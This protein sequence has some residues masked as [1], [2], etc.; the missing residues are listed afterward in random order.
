MQDKVR[1]RQ[2]LTYLLVSGI[3]TVS[4]GGLGAVLGA[5]DREERRPADITSSDPTNVILITADTLRADYLHCYGHENIDTPN[6]DQ[7]AGEGIQFQHCYCQSTTTNPSHASILTSLYPKDHQVYGNRDYLAEDLRLISEV[8]Q[9]NGFNTVAFVSVSHLNPGVSGFG[10][11]FNSFISCTS[12]EVEASVTNERVFSWFHEHQGSKS[13]FFMWVH[14][15][16]P[17]APY[18]PPG[19]F[20][21]MYYSGD[22]RDPRHSSMAEVRY[23]KRWRNSRHMEWLEGITDIEY[24]ISQYMGEVAY[25]DAQIGRLREGLVYYGLEKNTMIILT[26]DH[27]ESLGEHHI[28]FAHPGLYEVTTRVPLIF[29]YPCVFTPQITD[30]LAMSVDIVPTILDFLRIDQ[31]HGIRG[32]SLLPL[33]Q[34]GQEKVRA[35]VYCEYWENQVMVRGRK[36]KYIKSLKSNNYHEKFFVTEGRNELYDVVADPHE[37]INCADQYPKI[38]ERF[39]QQALAWLRDRRVSEGHRSTPELSQEMEENLRALGYID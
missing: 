4:S 35:S 5:C 22:P 17:H 39:D 38:V 28:Y 1:R 24:P 27:G 36:W 11:G 12:R 19:R 3:A 23:P 29:W 15:F 7:L 9:D 16:D 6:I 34:G 31:W 10:R 18:N 8:L 37:L 26:A 20:R 14:Y 21:T 25:L 32:K 33:L 2:F 13:P 30:N